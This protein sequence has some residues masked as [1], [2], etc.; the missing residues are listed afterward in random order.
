MTVILEKPFAGGGTYFQS[1]HLPE[2]KYLA[3]P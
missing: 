3:A 2:L 1:P